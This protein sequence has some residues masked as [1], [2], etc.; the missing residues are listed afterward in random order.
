MKT[1]AYTIEVRSSEGDTIRSEV[2]LGDNLVAQTNLNE[3]TVGKLATILAGNVL[4]LTV[5]DVPDGDVLYQP[6]KQKAVNTY[7]D[8]SCR[9]E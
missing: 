9:V 2:R 4:G 8:G 5:L 3:L 7:A 1:T 6:E